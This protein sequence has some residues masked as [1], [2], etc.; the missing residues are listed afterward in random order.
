[1]SLFSCKN[2]SKSYGGEHILN[3]IS[4]KLEPEE[5][6][7]LVGASGVGKTTLFNILA[8]VEK[9]DA[10]RVFLNESDITG[11]CGHVSYMPQNDLLFEHLTVLDNI[12]L[13]LIIQKKKRKEAR[14]YALSFFSRFGLEDCARKYPAQ[15]SGGMRQRAAFLRA[16]MLEKPV[17]LLD[18]PF[19]ALD[20]ITRAEIREWFAEI[21]RSLHLT[22]LCVTHDIDEALIL[23]KRIYVMKGRPAR[24]GGCYLAD[25]QQS[26]SSALTPSRLRLKQQLFS[27]LSGALIITQPKAV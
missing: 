13:P 8:G 6:V 21:S 14:E 10:G 12:T 23:S 25:G 16:C 17:M 3:G 20:F 1:M 15:L 26:G 7:S 11:V 2:I 22:T 24:I 9:A 18:E 4:L 27:A 5:F 19:S